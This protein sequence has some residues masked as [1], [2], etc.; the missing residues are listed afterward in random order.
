MAQQQVQQNAED[1]DLRTVDYVRMIVGGVVQIVIIVVPFILIRKLVKSA[2]NSK[3][4]QTV[5]NVLS[6]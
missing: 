5:N 1:E 3:T 4:F 6:D 2:E